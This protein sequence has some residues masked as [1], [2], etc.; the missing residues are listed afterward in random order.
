M[1]AHI[2]RK[3]IDVQDVEFFRS[4]LRNDDL[5]GEVGCQARRRHRDQGTEP[6][7]DADTGSQQASGELRVADHENLLSSLL[8]KE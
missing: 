8:P 5:A 7:A 6:G 1:D 4:V 2:R 3:S